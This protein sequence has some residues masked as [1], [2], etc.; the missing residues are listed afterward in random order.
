L[1]LSVRGMLT[2]LATYTIPFQIKM[3]NTK[4]N[5]KGALIML[6]KLDLFLSVFPNT[7][8]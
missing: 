1:E 5:F 6:R 8:F 7:S 2:Y 3:P 4:K